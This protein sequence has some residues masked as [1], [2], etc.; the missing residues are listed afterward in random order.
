MALNLNI[1]DPNEELTDDED[2]MDV[3]VIIAFPR[4]RKVIRPRPDHFTIW[5]NDEFVDRFRLSKNT[6][7]FLID[8]LRNTISSPTNW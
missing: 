4:R 6:T 1:I 3:A 5:R 7:W 2:F 8:R